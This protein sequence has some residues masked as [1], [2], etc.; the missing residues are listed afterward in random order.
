MKDL[1]KVFKSHKSG[2]KYVGIISKNGNVMYIDF[3]D[4]LNK[5]LLQYENKTVIV[6]IEISPQ[7]NVKV[8][9]SRKEFNQLVYA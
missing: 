7:Q 2:D 5:R 8:I 3:K 4:W 9:E 6:T 1:L